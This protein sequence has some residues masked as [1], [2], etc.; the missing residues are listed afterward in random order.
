MK[1]PRGGS[2]GALDLNVFPGGGYFAACG[3]VCLSVLLPPILALVVH[4][5]HVAP[6]GGWLPQSLVV[7][8]QPPNA[9]TENMTTKSNPSSQ[10]W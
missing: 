10:E 4:L 2:G 8:L 9:K 3:F 5:E 1:V 7:C 6:D